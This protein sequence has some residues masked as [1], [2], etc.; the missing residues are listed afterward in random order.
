[1]SLGPLKTDPEPSRM[2]A[3]LNPAQDELRPPRRLD[4]VGALHALVNAVRAR[5]LSGLIAALPI[6]LT[7]FIVHWLY[8][9]LTQIVLAPAIRAVK[10]VL[11]N[12]QLS[13]TFWD[14][15]FAPVIA[16][17]L[18]L[19][20][21]YSLGLFVQSR[22]VRA[23]DWVLLQVPIV[24][25]IFKAVSNVFQALG[26]QIQGDH[27]FK[28]VVL[29]EFP[30]PGARSLAFVTNTLH[31]AATDQTILC[32]CMLT[33]V[34]PPAGFTLFVP[35]ASVTDIDWSMNQTLQA[36]LSGGITSP[37]SIH[38]FQ[39]PQFPPGGPRVGT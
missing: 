2:S 27:G 1:L 3:P 26:K 6:A 35:E 22:V 9:T 14:T 34:M 20:L 13:D 29:V 16:V 37:S 21:L 23:V 8:V 33:G 12:Y 38:Y 28:R 15:Y 31:D 5:I 10:Y 7:F 30:H 11:G 32:V 39:G 18:V 24:N 25:T 19:F 17:I 4:E 36:I